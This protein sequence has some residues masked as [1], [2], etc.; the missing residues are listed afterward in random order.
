MFAHKCYEATW[1]ARLFWLLAGAGAVEGSAKWWSRGHRAH[2]RY[3]DTDQDP[4]SAIKGFWYAHIGWMLV[5]QDKDK[6]GRAD[7][8]D[9]NA[10]PL[11]RWQHK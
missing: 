6:I 7:I 3:V 4:Y 5:K 11:V 8:S 2:H 9:L 1:G 10:D